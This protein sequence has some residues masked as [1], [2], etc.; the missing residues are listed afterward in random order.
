MLIQ[1]SFWITTHLCQ[2]K[3]FKIESSDIL[4]FWNIFKIS[5]FILSIGTSLFE[6]LPSFSR[7]LHYLKTNLRFVHSFVDSCI[8]TICHPKD[9]TERVHL[10]GNFISPRNNLFHRQ[11]RFLLTRYRSPKWTPSAPNG[12]A[13][14]IAGKSWNHRGQYWTLNAMAWKPWISHP[15]VR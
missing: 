10:W 5:I 15:S 12:T 11:R 3:H 4:N 14:Q 8:R 2:V 13:N 6:V 9:F 7:K 1:E